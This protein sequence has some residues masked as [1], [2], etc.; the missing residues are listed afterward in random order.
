MKKPNYS[1]HLIQI[2]T[3]DFGVFWHS[4]AELYANEYGNAHKEILDI[5]VGM[6]V[7]AISSLMLN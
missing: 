4:R 6:F 3:S 2:S 7:I 5:L 1:N